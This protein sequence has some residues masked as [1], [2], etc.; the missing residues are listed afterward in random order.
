MTIYNWLSLFGVPSI[1]AA[2]LAY[3]M[4]RIKA[5]DTKTVSVQLG[6]QSLLMDR[7]DYLH[8]K[9]VSAGWVDVHKKRL[10]EN[11]YRQYAN[12]GADGVMAASWE[13]IQKLPTQPI[14]KGSNENETEN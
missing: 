6:V 7:L 9:Y 10:W 2:I 1:L 4:K 12:L 5:N 8:D 3:V 14:Q 11:M 13:D